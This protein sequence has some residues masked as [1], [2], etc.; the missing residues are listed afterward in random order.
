MPVMPALAT[1][2]R[3]FAGLASPGMR[4]TTIWV[5]ISIF[6]ALLAYFG[7]RS[8]LTPEL[9]FHFANFHVC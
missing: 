1:Q 7:F 9:L 3:T 5:V 4:R 8:Y 6:A 2:H